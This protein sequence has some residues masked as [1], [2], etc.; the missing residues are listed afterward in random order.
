MQYKFMPLVSAG[1]I[2]P[3]CGGKLSPMGRTSLPA[4]ISSEGQELHEKLLLD[5][6]QA[7]L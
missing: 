2:F 5:Y 6:S 1:A 3:E 4:A 7:L